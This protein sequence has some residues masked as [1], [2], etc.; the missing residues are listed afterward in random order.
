MIKL[1]SLLGNSGHHDLSATDGP[2]G[3]W[4]RPLEDSLRAYQTDKGLEADGLVLPKGPTLASL[5]GDLA[6][7]LGGFRAPTAQE[8][9]QHHMNNKLGEGGLLVGHKPPVQFPPTSWLA[10]VAG[11]RLR[12]LG[13]RAHEGAGP[14][15]H[16]R[17]TLIAREPSGAQSRAGALRI[18]DPGDLPNQA[19]RAVEDHG[20]PSTHPHAILVSQRERKW[21][22]SWMGFWAFSY[23]PPGKNTGSPLMRKAAMAAW[24]LGPVS[25]SCQAWARS[26]FTCGWRAGLTRIEP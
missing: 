20:A 4:G 19:K 3:W 11:G 9:D 7:K 1:E 23:L 13:F 18:G 24:P 25:H 12:A 22:S 2:T 15:R 6:P 26:A 16:C 14:R 8:V 10:S 5:K 17:Q 21:M